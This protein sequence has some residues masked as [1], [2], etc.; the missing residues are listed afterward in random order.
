MPLEQIATLSPMAREVAGY[1]ER[2]GA[3]FLSDIARGTGMLRVKVEE[4]LWQLVAHGLASGDGIA[5]LRVLL[6]PDHKR[7]ERRRSLHVI[8]GG[9]SPE[10]SM[11]VGRW[12][13]WRQRRSSED[14]TSGEAILERRARQLLQRY[15]V[16]FRELLAR[17]TIM[18]PWRSLLAVYRRLEARGEIRGGRFVGGFVGEQFALPQAIDS[19]RALRRGEEHEPPV[20]V[21]AADPLNLLGIVFPG[22]RVSPYSNQVIAYVDGLPVGVGLLGEILSRLQELPAQQS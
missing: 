9:R 17:E 4:A 18:P 21:S 13:L 19:L 22:T 3:S 6:T 5:G 8:S 14:S 7:V 12:A 10:R 16:V 11:P 2:H 20:V 1:L 15:G